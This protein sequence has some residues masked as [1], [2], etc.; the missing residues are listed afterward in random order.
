MA[1][2]HIEKL[3][4][5]DAEWKKLLT[6]EQYNILREEGTERPFTSALNHETHSGLFVC[7]ACGLPLVPIQI[8]I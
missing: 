6:P 8:Q 2:E 4:R 1:Q 7:V 3:M 5:S